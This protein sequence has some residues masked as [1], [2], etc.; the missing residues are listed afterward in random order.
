MFHASAKALEGA[1]YGDDRWTDYFEAVADEGYGIELYFPDAAEEDVERV[2]SY[3]DRL[4]DQEDVSIDIAGVHGPNQFD[5]VG[6][7][8][9]ATEA[10]E[11]LET[12]DALNPDYVVTHGPE[13]FVGDTRAEKQKQLVDALE[14]VYTVSEQRGLPTLLIENIGF[15][16]DDGYLLATPQDAEY[17]QEQATEHG[18]T[19]PTTLDTAH[20]A[21]PDKMFAAMNDVWNI[22]LN[23]R[24]P[25]GEEVSEDLGGIPNPYGHQ[26]HLPPKHQRGSLELEQ[27]IEELDTSDYNGYLTVE[28]ADTFQTQETVQDVAHLLKS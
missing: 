8:E 3:M 5:A 12:V 1:A 2:R 20:A 6:P 19:L 11:Y 24:T 7:E 26:E 9:Y 16:E 22:H 21:N 15:T 28:V 27:F 4:E 10:V 17:L 23:D 18:F 25:L 13:D 14:E